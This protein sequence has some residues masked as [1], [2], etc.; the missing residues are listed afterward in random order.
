MFAIKGYVCGSTPAARPCQRRHLGRRRVAQGITFL[1][2]QHL[3][4]RGVRRSWIVTL[5][6]D[7]EPTNWPGWPRPLPHSIQGQRPA[8]RECEAIRHEFHR[9]S[10]K[11]D[12]PS[13]AI[14]ANARFP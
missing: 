8:H 5:L 2:C 11:Q 14:L 13:P 9:A 1:R 12:R 6:R 10:V 7:D 3:D 4:A